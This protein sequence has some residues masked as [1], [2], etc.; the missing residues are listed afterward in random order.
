MRKRI[1]ACSFSMCAALAM[2]ACQQKQPAAHV[3]T[4]ARKPAVAPVEQRSLPADVRTIIKASRER[5]ALG[6]YY[7]PSYYSIDYPG[8]DVPNDRGVCTDV[9]IRAYRRIGIDFQ[10]LIHEDMSRSFP[11]YPRLWQNRSTDRN[12]DHRR[13][14]NIET[15]LNRKGASLPITSRGA[16]YHPGDLVTWRLTGGLPHIGIV[17]DRVVPRSDRPLILHNI[18][19]GTAEDDI[20]FTYPIAGHFRY[21]PDEAVH[22]R[23]REHEAMADSGVTTRGR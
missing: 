19:A 13:V 2:A 17:S 22:S 15:F 8:G 5:M 4:P 1:A 3:E 14:P 12:I 20:L 11:A 6:E 7:D 23:K 18:G 10:Q 16:D 21:F 9:V